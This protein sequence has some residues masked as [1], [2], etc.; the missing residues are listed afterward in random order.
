MKYSF[1]KCLEPRFIT[2]IYTGEEV[3]VECGKCESCLMKK[4]L[5][6]T[7]R[8]KLES[9]VHRYTFFST[10]TYDNEH[11]PLARLVNNNDKL[12]VYTFVEEDGNVLGKLSFRKHIDKIN[13]INKCNTPHDMLPYLRKRDVQL[14]LKRLRKYIFKRTNEK[15]R[16]FYCGEYG[17]V[18]FRPHFHLL[19]WF[20][21]EETL[22]NIRE[23]VS[24]CWSF[25]RVDAQLSSGKSSSYVASYLNST[26]YLPGVFK[27]RQTAP[28]SNHSFYLGESVFQ[29]IGKEIQEHEFA[30]AAKKRIYGNGINTDCVLWR[31]LKT[32]VLSKCKGYNQKSE[33]MRIFSYQLY[34]KLR[35]W[36]QEDSPLYQAR[37]VTDYVI[38]NDFYSPDDEF[39]EMLQYF[40][41][42][43]G[44]YVKQVDETYRYVM[45]FISDW[46][47]FERSVY[48][49]LLLSRRF[50]RDIC[51][52]NADLIGTRLK[53]IN[54]F[55][56]YLDY[57]NL[58]QQLK[59]ES[60][61]S[62]T[63]DRHL[64]KYFFHNTLLV[65][66]L[67][68]ESVFKRFRTAKKDMYKDFVK[69]KELNDKNKIFNYI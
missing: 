57:E 45:P 63:A 33:H 52:G 29:N 38:L 34:E 16:V 59:M 17:P 7:T 40:R 28:F 18:H 10:L 49:E 36:T 15:I 47:K 42:S 43:Y 23:A 50:I 39:N 41:R 4:S 55:Y 14:F 64:N 65:D 19:L 48:M 8:C 67:K 46:S 62:K 35:T 24:A 26:M 5:A 13:L 54:K 60:D 58:K 2:N 21:K 22:S 20:D 27:L 30:R 31:S 37:F 44:T 25:G 69:H 61:I 32:R 53:T 11:L 51:N 1:I 6:R 9:S 66:E 3:F 56:E 68:E 12:N